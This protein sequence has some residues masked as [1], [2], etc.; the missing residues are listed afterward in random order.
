LQA[1][2]KELRI[3]DRSVIVEAQV[4]TI[5]GL[6]AHADQ[7]ELTAWLKDAAPPRQT[8]V[9]HGEAAARQGFAEHITR[10]LGWTTNCPEKGQT[11]EL[12]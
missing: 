11:V 8:F 4:V 2:T 12:E 7:A 3:L 6:S 10:T 5:D 9:V 1:G